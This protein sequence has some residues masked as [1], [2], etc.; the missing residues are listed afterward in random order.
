M[1][2]LRGGTR[3]VHKSHHFSIFRSG[4]LLG[5]ALPAAIDGLVKSACSLPLDSYEI[6]VADGVE[7]GRLSAGNAHSAPAVGWADVCVWCATH[8]NVVRV[9]R[10]GKHHCVVQ[11]KN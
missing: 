5:L 2:R 10:L 7:Y 1:A 9:P 8:T 11:G 6:A 4:A 3:A